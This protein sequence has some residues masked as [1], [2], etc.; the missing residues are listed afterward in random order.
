M[1][2]VTVTDGRSSTPRQ[3]TVEVEVE[4]DSGASAARPCRRAPRPGSSR[5]SSSA[6]ATPA[7]TSARVSRGR[8]ERRAGARA[9]AGRCGRGRPGGRRPA[10]PR[11]RRDAQQ[12]PP[13]RE[14]AARGLPRRGEGGRARPAPLFRY[15]GGESAQVLP[16]PL[17][18][19]VNGG[20]HAQN[21]L[22]LQ[23]FM[24]VPAGPRRSPRPC[25]SARRPSTG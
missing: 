7:P 14:R 2:I 16:V 10:P 22:D 6:T 9:G 5:R 15:L 18:N 17:M 24:V 4:L 21:S 3:P 12:V 23:E 13:R 8:R 1:K 25:G 11:A 19:V 20:A